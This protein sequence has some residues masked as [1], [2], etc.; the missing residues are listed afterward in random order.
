MFRMTIETQLNLKDRTLLGGRPDVCRIPKTI[1]VGEKTFAV[2][3][4]SSGVRPPFLS[5]EIEKTAL[6]LIGQEAVE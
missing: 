3:G 1:R 2:M 5:L 4:A 6:S